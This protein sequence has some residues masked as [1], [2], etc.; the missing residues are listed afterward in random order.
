MGRI[1]LIGLIGFM[2][3][4]AAGGAEIVRYVDP[5]AT[6]TPEDGTTWAKAYAS[7]NA[8]LTAEATNLVTAGNTFRI[9]CHSSGTD[10]T[11]AAT[12]SSSW[13]TGAS[14]TL[15]IDANSTYTLAGTNAVLLTITSNYVRINGLYCEVTESGGSNGRGIYVTGTVG[16]T[17]IRIGDCKITGTCT[18]TSQ[19]QGILVNDLGSTVVLYNTIVT[20]FVNDANTGFQAVNAMAGTVAI[21]NCTIYG[22]YYGILRPGGGATTT[23]T[24]CAVGGNTD[25]F[26]GTMTI[27]YC[28][29]DDGDGTHAQGPVSGDWDNEFTDAAGGDF[30]LLEAGNCV[31]HGTDDPGSGLYSDDFA[32]TDRDTYSPWDIGA[33]EF[34]SEAPES[35]TIPV[36]MHHYRSLQNAD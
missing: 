27:D 29:S 7:L 10:D 33:Y 20:N 1:G 26:S 25:D 17:D 15:A 19:G 6:G 9:R 28:C 5:D 12:I 21:Y 13:V 8:A 18:G 4:A 23:V 24:N 35:A 2:L 34:M 22:N 36:F 14:N 32:G 31:N 11:T 16:D 30:T 3:A